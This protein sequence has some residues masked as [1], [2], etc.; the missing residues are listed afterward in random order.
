MP[1]TATDI[2]WRKSQRL[3]D[4]PDGGG[5]MVAAEVVYD[6][7]NNLF[8]D[9]GDEARTTGNVSLRKAFVHID[10]TTVDPLKDAI[11]IIL[12][13][14][15]DD[16]VSM[17]M[18]STGSY[19]DTRDA[20]RNRIEGYITRGVESRFILMGDHYI[21][22]R[23]MTLYCMRDAASPEV[24]DNLCLSTE[25]NG[26][27]PDVQYVR[28]EKV[29]AR[30]TQT[31]ID[32][33]GA[34]ERDVLVISI[35]TPLLY[36]FYGQEPARLTATKP[37]TRVRSTNVV[38]AANYY[39]IKPLTVAGGLGDLSVDVGSP[40]V[41]L[42]PST[43]AETPVVDVLAGLGTI[44]MVQSGPTDGL[45][46][47]TS[48]TYSSGVAAVR[49]MGSPLFRG[50][51]TVGLGATTLT[52]NG[53]G[54]LSASGVSSWSGTVDYTAG[55]IALTN[56]SGAGSVQCAIT[57]TAA[58]AVSTQ[59]YTYPLAV[60]Q[61]NQQ[62]SYVFAL[63]PT[64]AAGT[65]IFDYRVLG[66][67]VRLN[68]NG[69]GQLVG[70]PGE[71]SGTINY[72]TGS[73]VVTL[74]ALPDVD[75]TMIV[76]YGTGVVTDR[77]DGDIM[78]K[79]PY[80]NYLLPDTGIKPTSFS[81]SWLEATTVK[82]AADDGSGALKLAGV[83]IGSIVYATGEVGFRPTTLPD[84]GSQITN[85]YTYGVNQSNTFTPP[86][87]GSGFATITIPDAPVRPGAVD[88][89]WTCAS[90][91]GDADVGA[92]NVPVRIVARDDGQGNIVAVSA[93]GAALTG[94]LGTINYTAGTIS[95]KVS[96]IQIQRLAKGRYRT[97]SFF[98]YRVDG[99]V[100]ETT[101]AVFPQSGFVTVRWQVAA[102]TD[103]VVTG[104]AVPLPPVALDLTPDVLD[105]I[106]PGG[107]RFTFRG[108]TYVDR[109]G[110]LYYDISPTTGAGSYAG[111]MDYASGTARITQ[112]NAGGT[113]AV[114][115]NAL[116]TRVGDIGT[117][118]VTFRAPGSPL[119]P[120]S[121]TMRA[122]TA[123]GEQLTALADIDGVITG[124]SVLGQVDWATGTIAVRFGEYVTSAGNEGEPWYRPQDVVGTQV[125]RPRLV[126][127]DTIYFGTV[128]YR[129]IPLSS[130]VLGLDPVRLPS[131]GRVLAFKAGQTV[132]IH[133][134]ETET[135][136]PTANQVVD[137]GR[138]AVSFVE[139]RDADG[140]PI[141]SVWYTI[142]LAAGTVTWA[143]VLNLSANTMPVSIRHTIADRRLVADVQVTGRIDLNT[144]LSR[145]FPVGAKVSTALRLGEANGSLD[146]QA[147]VQGV[148]DQETWTGAWSDQRI[149]NGADASYN[150]VDFPVVVDNANAITERWVIEFTSATAFKV[151]GET[152]G[153]IATG[154][155]T[156][157]I[158]PL[159]PRTSLPY[160]AID[161]DGWG[162][163]W[164]AGNA[165][166]FNTIGALAPV[167]LAR[168]VLAG[169]PEVAQDAFRLQVVGN[170][171]GG[172][173]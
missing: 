73:L 141:D 124:D 69:A 93:S 166:R 72:L 59:G 10:T 36:D 62:L 170:I 24:N 79:P 58:A 14:P 34:F 157:D 78:I 97:N 125:W 133:H 114:A 28:V 47:S 27:D 167:W 148:F 29:Q 171:T 130:V 131:D 86:V 123:D 33:Q 4:N 172:A 161:K 21:G 45:N 3:T 38:D 1:I 111:T 7:F 35:T 55:S 101:L 92:P 23:A 88:F 152:I 46:N 163:G 20:A 85:S 100:R 84:V 80:L 5:R 95:L 15:E 68:D 37:P 91:A 137:L 155:I 126:L 30:S 11:A 39:S 113:N 143:A 50:S 127:P 150:D 57:A 164:A 64:P 145:I 128:I 82:T 67:W 160:F 122:S 60:T 106:V 32:A 135:L 115:V 48:L 71:G 158:A 61:G 26:Y 25:A 149:G 75:T 66:K 74:A 63:T 120:G 121:F 102:A 65:V 70:N 147:R 42:V 8:S 16:R 98:R 119:R 154:N 19:S 112:W 168:T 2:K 76:S 162:G 22:S 18:F 159:N 107:V 41:P 136:T 81:V 173:A 109:S 17:T 144:G 156:A 52:D 89:E 77:R 44:S 129:S 116:L 146:L 165:L 142:S 117:D 118:E 51:V 103:N 151:I 9:I 134:S 96:G 105:S 99:I 94:T 140:T 12:D 13:G 104:L 49:Y 43:L 139:V 40:Y 87:D 31:F 83:T 90:Q 108:R 132:V 110:S 153:Q 54:T 53:D 138:T 56:D 6:E 169:A